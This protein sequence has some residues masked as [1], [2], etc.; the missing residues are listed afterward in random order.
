MRRRP[1]R[2]L[3]SARSMTAAATKRFTLWFAEGCIESLVSISDMQR[4]AAEEE[5]QDLLRD[6]DSLLKD[7]NIREESKDE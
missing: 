1:T 7:L 2:L 3:D 6:I 4:D 5:N